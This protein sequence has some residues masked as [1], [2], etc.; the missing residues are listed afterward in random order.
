MFQNN[1]TAAMSVYPENLLGVEF[2]SHVNAFFCSNKLAW[3]LAK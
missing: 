2:F 1:E 3:K